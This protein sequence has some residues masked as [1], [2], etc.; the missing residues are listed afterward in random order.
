MS[1]WKQALYKQIGMKQDIERIQKAHNENDAERLIRILHL[2]PKRSLPDLIHAVRKT[3]DLLAMN[4]EQFYQREER[5]IKW[6]EWA[7]GRDVIKLEKA[8]EW[9]Y[10]YLI[11]YLYRE[12]IDAADPDEKKRLMRQYPQVKE[13]QSMHFLTTLWEDDDA[14]MHFMETQLPQ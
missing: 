6:A 14:F 2:V 11:P 12:I 9:T 3:D 1:K 4:I 13:T 10:P 5:A 7:K 8:F